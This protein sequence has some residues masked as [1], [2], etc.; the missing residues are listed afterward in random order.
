MLKKI[1]IPQ[2]PD[3]KNADRADWARLAI[4]EFRHNTMPDF[5]MKEVLVD[6]L[7]DI[8]HL[9][10]REQID[11]IECIRRAS[12]HYEKETGEDGQQFER[13]SIIPLLADYTLPKL[14]K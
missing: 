2:D 9:C 7:T 13:I 10:D 1:K 11:L 14:S 3:Q 4:D 8:A 6:L 12:G 5:E